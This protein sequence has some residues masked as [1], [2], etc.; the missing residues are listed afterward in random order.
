[1]FSCFQLLVVR[2]NVTSRSEHDVEWCSRR[3]G[4][5]FVFNSF[6]LVLLSGLHFP[7]VIF[8]IGDVYSHNIWR[9]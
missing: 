1:M 7:G 2:R 3:S 4:F 8:I 6:V 5:I 9:Q